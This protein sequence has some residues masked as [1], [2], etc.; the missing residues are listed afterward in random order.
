MKKLLLITVLFACENEVS[1]CYKLHQESIQAYKDMKA[2][3]GTDEYEEAKQR[4]LSL[5]DQT[6]NCYGR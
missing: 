1:P 6:D 3:Q 5:R 4:F 2:V